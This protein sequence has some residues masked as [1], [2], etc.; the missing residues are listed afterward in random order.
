MI[1]SYSVDIDTKYIDALITL[2]GEEKAKQIIDSMLNSLSKEFTNMVWRYL[3]E[4]SP[5]EIEVNG[6]KYIKKG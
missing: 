1:N 6:V 4:K 3:N 2:Y 5:N